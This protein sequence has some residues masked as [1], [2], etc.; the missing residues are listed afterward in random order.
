MNRRPPAAVLRQLRQEVRFGCPHCRSPLLEWHHFDPPWHEGHTHNPDGMIALCRKCHAFADA[1]GWS[2][3]ELVA[4][5]QR[6]HSLPAVEQL[7]WNRHNLVMLVGSNLLIGRCCVICGPNDSSL[8]LGPD[9]DG[10]LAVTV[11]LTDQHGHVLVSI[12]DGYLEVDPSI[13]D[14]SIT[15]SQT[16]LSA[17]IESRKIGLEVEFKRV[18]AKHIIERMNRIVATLENCISKNHDIHSL[19]GVADKEECIPVVAVKRLTTFFDGTKVQIKGDLHVGPASFD[20]N[21]LLNF[22]S[23]SRLNV[24][25]IA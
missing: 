21:I 19:L 3:Q 2:S 14:F 5:K 24:L 17:W 10:N 25:A 22:C 1:N 15:S 7:S 4:F 11:K 8:E 16:G 13:H 18:P 20:G 12:V 9:S 23:V 6:A